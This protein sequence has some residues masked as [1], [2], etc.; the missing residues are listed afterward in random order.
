MRRGVTVIALLMLGARAFAQC[1]P[2]PVAAIEFDEDSLDQDDDGEQVTGEFLKFRARPSE[3]QQI[4][5]VV[6]TIHQLPPM[7]YGGVGG[8]PLPAEQEK[9]RRDFKI[10][11]I[12][13]ARKTGHLT[14]PPGVPA[15]IVITMTDTARKC[16]KVDKP[17]ST[18]QVGTFAV[19]VGIKEYP[20]SQQPLR[21]GRADAEAMAQ[22][23]LDNFDGATKERI[24]LL[25]DKPK[26]NEVSLWTGDRGPADRKTIVRA[27]TDAS[28][29]LDPSST[30]IFYFSG[31]GFAPSA[32]QFRYG[33]Y[34]LPEETDL[35]YDDSMLEVS[36]ISKKFK[37]SGVH[38]GIV[39]LDACFTDKK[40]TGIPASLH[41]TKALGEPRDFVGIKELLDVKQAY[42]MASSQEKQMSYELDK[43]GHGAFTCFLLKGVPP[44]TTATGPAAPRDLTIGG[45]FRLAKEA[46]KGVITDENGN[47][48]QDP[49][50]WSFNGGDQI[51]WVR[52]R[53]PG[54]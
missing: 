13:G 37:Q 5:S 41:L 19:V 6:I 25:T 4:Q 28:R 35:D 50:D 9:G 46:V 2:D 48:L 33:A 51:L 17:V 31:H 30:L 10:P 47:I 34:L 1:G 39:I 36:E 16:V 12:V 38:R 44:A 11:Y 22:Y 42:V 18:R 29:Q 20:A 14:L 53:P 27:L 21:W 23:I 8:L 3:N 15:R 54:P 49:G 7:T 26:P 32:G 52:D 24:W 43:C 40:A 45:A